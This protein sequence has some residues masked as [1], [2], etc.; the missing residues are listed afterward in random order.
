MPRPLR[1]FLASLA[2]LAAGCGA[3]FDET[4][5]NAKPLKV[6]HAS[7]WA[8]SRWRLFFRAGA[9]RPICAVP[10]SGSN[11]RSCRR[12]LSAWRSSIPT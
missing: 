2:L 5:E 6:S 12:T 4:R 8:C 1:A 11:R 9:P 3:G 10:G 7:R